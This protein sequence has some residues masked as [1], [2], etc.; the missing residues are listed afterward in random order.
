M[1]WL[2]LALAGGADVFPEDITLAG[3]GRR[4]RRAAP[5]QEV[6]CWDSPLRSLQKALLTPRCSSRDSGRESLLADRGWAA[7]PGSS[8]G[9]QSAAKLLGSATNLPPQCH[10]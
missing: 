4:W 2:G 5:E 1:S 6:A 3:A 8:R 7:S 9:P 10:P